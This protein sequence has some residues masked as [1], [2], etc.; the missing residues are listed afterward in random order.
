MDALENLYIFTEK[1]KQKKFN[2]IAFS[3]L[4]GNYTVKTSPL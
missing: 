3:I 2:E 4:H 1:K